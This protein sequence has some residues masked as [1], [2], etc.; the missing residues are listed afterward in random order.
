MNNTCIVCGSNETK[1][2]F[3]YQVVQTFHIRDLSGEKRV[4]ALGERDSGCL[5][6]ACM[7]KRLKDNLNPTKL[8]FKRLTLFFVLFA[9][10]LGVAIF[11]FK[12]DTTLFMFGLAAIACSL[13]VGY[14]RI[15]SV[16]RRKKEFKAYTQK[17]AEEEAAWEAFSNALP[18]K[19]EDN[20]LTYIPI[21]KKT[22][23]MKN[24]DLMIMY[25]LLPEIAKKAW[26]EIRRK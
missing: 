6:E 11:F 23:A 17:D 16:T 18:K 5:C 4:Q 8:L 15:R 21:N 22:L 20:D 14:S 13:M 26:S 25:N 10:G 2:K 24:G 19:D 12:K 1:F 9:I 3:D 7:Q